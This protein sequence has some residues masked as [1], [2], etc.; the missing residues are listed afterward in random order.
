MAIFLFVKNRV[1]LFVIGLSSAIFL[2]C[3]ILFWWVYPLRYK[4]QIIFY[5]Q[6]YQL[7]SSF[8]SAVICTESRFDKNAISSSGASGLMQ[9]MPSTYEWVKT[10]IA[11]LPDDIFDVDANI[12]A[13]CF[14]LRYLI[15][16]YQ[17]I[18]YVLACYN[19]G[20]GVVKKW[21]NSQNFS[22]ND[23]QYN[24]TKQYVSR[25][26]KLK[27]LYAARFD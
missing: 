3:G 7:E 11:N 18:V 6:K 27:N 23:I 15:D 12:N 5:A 24:E 8:V 25:V 20:E 9:L 17:N 21:G 10:S 19:A 1:V 13:G 4:S 14:Y 26:L 16:K 22:L 2:C